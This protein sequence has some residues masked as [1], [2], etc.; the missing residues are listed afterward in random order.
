MAQFIKCD[1]CGSQV[2]EG[3]TGAD[4]HGIFPIRRVKG[5]C[6][7]C[8]CRESYPPLPLKV[9]QLHL[10]VMQLPTLHFVL[11]LPEQT[12]IPTPGTKGKFDRDSIVLS[13]PFKIP[14]PES[15]FGIKYQGE[16][17]TLSPQLK[18]TRFSGK[19]EPVHYCTVFPAGTRVYN[20]YS[21]I[22]CEDLEKDTS[23]VL[24][25]FPK[26]QL[27]S[28]MVEVDGLMT[29]LDGPIYLF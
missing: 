5:G 28:K 16:Q 27:S 2:Q 29:R 1:Y 24:P 10:K 9:M 25:L 3:E 20:E 23:V 7:F 22:Q 17:F 8:R 26:I 18:M 19:M 6:I 13:E 11:F 15:G 4:P 21:H 12:C 14:I